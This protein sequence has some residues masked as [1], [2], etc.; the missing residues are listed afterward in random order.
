VVAD[1][2]VEPVSTPIR[3]EAGVEASTGVPAEGGTPSTADPS[4]GLM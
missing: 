2:G 1:A 3:S 4:D